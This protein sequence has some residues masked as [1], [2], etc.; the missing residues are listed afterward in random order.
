MSILPPGF[1][2]E[3]KERLGHDIP[4]EDLE[5]MAAINQIVLNLRWMESV[6]SRAR[7]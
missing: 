2:R 3:W 7:L 5:A 4:I 1:Y 6:L